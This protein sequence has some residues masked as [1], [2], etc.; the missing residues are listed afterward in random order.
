MSVENIRTLLDW[1]VNR[2][3]FAVTCPEGFATSKELTDIYII[4]IF[5]LFTQ[6]SFPH[7][8][9]DLD[10]GHRFKEKSP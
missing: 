3:D 1:T 8:Q 5:Y 10:Q 6:Y 4:N 2:Q 9:V 7:F